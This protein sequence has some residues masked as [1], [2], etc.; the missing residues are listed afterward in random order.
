MLDRNRFTAD[1]N[2]A[3]QVGKLWGDQ[4][5]QLLPRGMEY[6]PQPRTTWFAEKASP[7]VLALG[8][9]IAKLTESVSRQ[10]GALCFRSA[11]F[12]H[13]PIFASGSAH[14][15]WSRMPS[16]VIHSWDYH[17]QEKRLDVKFT[18]GRRYSYH[19]VEPAIADGL[20]AASSK[21]EYFN[22]VIRDHYRYTRLR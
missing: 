21:G 6:D 12:L 16:S 18:T 15:R 8:E 20:R 2:S 1:D 13:R 7:E 17:A 11:Q 14:A 22:T 3:W 5:P 9:N 19:D 4:F 10:G